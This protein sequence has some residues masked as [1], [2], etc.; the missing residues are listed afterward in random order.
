MIIDISTEGG[1]GRGIHKFL[2]FLKKINNNYELNNIENNNNSK[3]IFRAKWFCQ[4][5][6]WNNK[7]KKYI[8]W[9]GESYPPPKSE[10]ETK[11]L[12]IITHIDPLLNSLY[13]PYF[14]YS[15]Y[16]YQD[17][18]HKNSNRKYLI[19]YC[20]RN[21]VKER[22]EIFNLFVEKSSEEICHSLSGACGNYPKTKI[23][24]IGGGWGSKILIDT[25]KD[26][27]F[28]IAME[29]KIVDGYITEKILNAFAS[30]A[31]PIF[32]GSNK[33]KEF[34]NEKA[35]INVNDFK[36]F[37]GCVDYCINLSDEQ[38]S[39]MQNEP[40]YTNNELVNIFNENFEKNKNGTNQVLN[41]YVQKVKEFIQ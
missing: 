26:Y 20:H 9:S 6:Y 1:G 39:K 23:K 27:K 13:I 41:D 40:I 36:S 28:V 33:V 38:I 37:E 30:G 5:K 18:Y 12:Y 25:Y 2:F 21:I 35:F 34:F 7:P 15:P 19:A 14:L 32:W 16:L 29:N 22:E 10:F 8:Y 4:E 24:S 17:R 3:I 31:I 11:S